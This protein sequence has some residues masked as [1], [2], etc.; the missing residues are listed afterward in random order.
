MMT[1]TNNDTMDRSEM[2]VLVY[3]RLVL[4]VECGLDAQRR[5]DREETVSHLTHARD[6]VR[7]LQRSIRVEEH[8][9]GYDLA[10]LHEFLDRRVVMATIGLG[11]AVTDDC[12]RLVTDVCLGWREI[13]QSA[14]VDRLTA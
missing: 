13:V 1:T 6:I 10:A 8:R 5:G 9:G 2:L 12:L 11:T 14:S 3:D 4:D 7:E